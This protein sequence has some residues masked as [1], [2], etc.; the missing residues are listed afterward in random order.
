MKQTNN[1][2]GWRSFLELCAGMETAADFDQLFKL[3]LTF[4]ERK[5]VADRY[6]IVKALLA[7]DKPQRQIAE[8]L[9]VSIAKITRGSNELKTIDEKSKNFLK[10]KIN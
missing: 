9:Q 6:L 2:D 1:E 4:D 7:G 10:T 3:F 5:D 8:E